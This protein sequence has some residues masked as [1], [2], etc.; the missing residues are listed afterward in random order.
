M[1]A[2]MLGLVIVG[3]GLFF[4]VSSWLKSDFPIDR[5]FVARSERLWGDKVHVFLLFSWVAIILVGY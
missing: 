1:D 2:E 3:V 4:V 5:L